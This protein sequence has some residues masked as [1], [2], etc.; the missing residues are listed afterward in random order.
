VKANNRLR[1]R[2]LSPPG[3]AAALPVYSGETRA[4]PAILFPGVGVA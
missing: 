2:S 1:G 4:L 3:K